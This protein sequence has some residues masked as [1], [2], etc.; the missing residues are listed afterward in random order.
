MYEEY[1]NQST[2]ALLCMTPLRGTQSLWF[3]VV[4]NAVLAIT[5]TLG[6]TL[7]LIALYKET[8]L[9]PTSKILLRSLAFTDFFVGIFLEPLV[10][11]ALITAEYRSLPFCYYIINVCIVIG[12]PLFFASLF[13][14]TAV[15]VDRLLALLLGIRYRQVVTVKRVLLVVICFWTLGVSFPL[16]GI[17]NPNILPYYGSIAVI[18]NLVT[19]TCS[20]SRIYQKLLRHQIQVQEHVPQGQENGHKPLNIARYRKTVSSALWIQFTVLVCYL[21]VGVLLVAMTVKGVTLSLLAAWTF[22]TTLALLNSSL[23]P[24]LYCWKMREVRRAVIDTTKKTFCSFS[25]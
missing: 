4:F 21:P 5:S 6:N 9:H 23:N 12:L 19:S 1:G 10:V 8:S 20:Y 24:I 3:L 17:L 14:L 11:M 22:T 18:L 13:T 15:S 25:G 2:Q 7:I 16:W